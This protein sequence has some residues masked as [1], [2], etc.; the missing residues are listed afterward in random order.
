MLHTV[1]SFFY[2][3]YTWNTWT[4]NYFSKEPGEN[5]AI[6][7]RDDIK[8]H[9][10][11]QA[12]STFSSPRAGVLISLAGVHVLI[13]IMGF[14]HGSNDKESAC[15]Y[16]Q[17]EFDPWVRKIPWRREWL[18]TLGFLPGES[19]EQRSLVG[20]SPW[21]CKESD[22]TERLSTFTLKRL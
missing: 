19:H 16:R 7:S 12:V 5:Q 1:I 8:L 2:Y 3:Y 14:P 22:M 13:G 20:Y 18:P 21:G 11:G 15:Q 17:T 9:Y 10:G 4:I 6:K